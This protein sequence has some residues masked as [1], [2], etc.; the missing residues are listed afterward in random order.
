MNQRGISLIELLV[1][2][3]ISAFLMMGLVQVYTNTL[4]NTDLLGHMSALQEKVRFATDLT[5][6]DIRNAGYSGC[7]SKPNADT[8]IIKTDTSANPEFQPYNGIAGWDAPAAYVPITSGASGTAVATVSGGWSSSTSDFVAI[9]NTIKSVPGSDVL[10]IWNGTSNSAEISSTLAATA[11]TFIPLDTAAT[12]VTNEYIYLGTCGNAV[13]LKVCSGTTPTSINIACN[14][15]VDFPGGLATG[16]VYSLRAVTYFVGKLNNAS[17]SIPALFRD[18]GDGTGPQEVVRGVESMQVLYGVDLNGDGA[19]AVD[20][21]V[22]AANVPSWDQVKSVR[23]SM[24]VQSESDNVVSQAQPFNF[25]GAT[26]TPTDKRLRRVMTQTI[27]LRNRMW[28]P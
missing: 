16:R 18:A 11:P 26:V 6:Q 10:R 3:A 21:W 8:F 1:A 2:L 20:G 27:N 9:E 13:V 19:Q 5:A 14:T 17:S 23:L 22:T 12:F 4:T 24:V 25:N 15:S 7:G 28:T